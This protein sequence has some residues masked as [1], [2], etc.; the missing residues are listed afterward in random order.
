MDR[1]HFLKLAGA[2]PAAGFVPEVLAARQPSPRQNPRKLVLVRL[3][4]GNDALN[5]LIPWYDYDYYKKLRPRISMPDQVR[6][7]EKYQLKNGGQQSLNPWLKDLMPWWDKG[8][9]AC[10]QGVGYPNPILSH[11]ESADIWETASFS[12]TNRGW[13]SHVMPG[14]KRDL[15]GIVLGGEELGALS[16]KDCYAICMKSPEVFLSQTNLVDPVQTNRRLNP[17]LS[18]LTNIQSQ[19]VSASNQLASK[20]SRP[21]P[22]GPWRARSEIGRQLES[23]AKMIVNG[24]DAP[25]YLVELDGFDTHAN[26]LREQNHLLEYLGVALNSFAETMVRHG[27]WNNTL[28]LTYSEF[29][30]RVE[31]NRAGGTDHGAASLQLA[32]GG[33]VRGGLYGEKPN[34][35]RLD[36]AGNLRMSVDFR[37][38]Y[39]TVAQRWFRQSNPWGQLGTLP[40]V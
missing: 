11:F 3:K 13:L 9:L 18:H 6:N 30:R 23:V 12:T 24:I 21:R 33:S 2:L 20:M 5:T 35:R 31:E 40:F 19:V 16:G 27:Q 10:I 8:Q 37:Q 29:G 14:Y 1:R 28:V 32:M 38:V 7:L 26:Q 17:A 36:N 22:I 39:G 25:V 4:G 34:L 15:H